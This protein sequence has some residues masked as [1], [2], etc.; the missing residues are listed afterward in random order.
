[1]L[2]RDVLDG[3]LA[4]QARGLGIEPIILSNSNRSLWATAH[5]LSN[6]LQ[7]RQI[8]IVHVHG[9]KA[10]IVCAMARLS[11]RFAIVKTVHGLPEPMEGNPLYALRDRF[12]H[13]LDVIATRMTAETVC[14]VTEELRKKYARVHTGLRVAVIPNGIA[15]MEASRYKHPTQFHKDWFNLTIVGRL[16]TVKGHDVAIKAISMPNVPIDDL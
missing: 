9:Y 6:I 13:F 1:M 2:E 11:Y 7:Q 16:D 15:E 4:I 8:R 12:Y 5:T 14:Y 10:A 3:E